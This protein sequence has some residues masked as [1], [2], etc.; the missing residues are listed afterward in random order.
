MWS[1][2]LA[3]ATSA[4]PTAD[5]VTAQ[6]QSE[7]QQRLHAQGSGAMVQVGL[8]RLQALPVGAVQIEIGDVAGRWPR[9]RASVP[10]RVRMDGRVLRTL[11]VPVT[12]TDLR[13]VQVFDANYVARTGL[14][15]LRLREATMD[16]VCCSGTV[17]VGLPAA[18][19]RLRQ[20]VRAGTPL[21]DA[22]LEPLPAVQGMQEVQLL[23]RHKG[24][25]LSAAAVALQDGQ[26]GQRIAVR[27]SYAHETVVATVTAPGKVQ[28]HE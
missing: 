14:A 23:V 2:L 22:V 7:L 9:A 1:L 19:Y 16:M 28:I 26:V 20:D 21:T 5:A 18:G 6:I 25:E 3:L 24:I 10:V 15:T 4:A 11:N 12:A 8:V 27:P 17:L 13:S